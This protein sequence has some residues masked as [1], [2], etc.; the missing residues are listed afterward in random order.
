MDDPFDSDLLDAM[1]E[2][3][4]LAEAEGDLGDGADGEAFGDAAAEDLFADG[5]EASSDEADV[6]ADGS[7][8]AADAWDEGDAGEVDAMTLWNAF[9]EDVAAGLDEAD[10]DEFLGRLLGGLT[11]VGGM[12]G[13]G[14]R[15]A[16]GVAGRVAGT[17]Q[18][19]G[20]IAGRA[21]SMIG[22]TAPVMQGAAQM[23]RVLGAPG[24]GARLDSLGRGL[25]HA[26]QLA[27]NVGVTA[28]GIGRGA[29]GVEQ[30]LQGRFRAGAGQAAAGLRQAV[31]GGQSIL[32][33]L[34]RLFGSGGN[35]FDDFDAMAELYI[36]EGMDEALP[37]AV[38]LAARAAARGLGFGNIS[39]LSLAARRSL[40]RGV[41]AAA[42]E[43]IQRR[44][45][46]AVRA[47]PRLV[48][49][50]ARVARRNAPTPARAVRT[51]RQG[52]PQTARRVAANPQALRRLARPVPPGRAVGR[53]PALGH[54]TSGN[55]IGARRTFHID[56]PATLTITPR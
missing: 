40:V 42:R 2:A 56:G 37:A 15:T 32:A 26:G 19:V 10:E 22:A 49:S 5:Q 3:D 24:V 12:I 29:G 50:A 30:I 33:H 13:R 43:L 51:L 6:F 23:A 18:Q 4:A 39:Q 48:Q 36:D 7:A 17:A 52:M 28:Q 44:G 38:A 25:G 27:H 47:L 46:Q 20:H 11:R 16:R 8:D 54:G 1:D 41:A 34:G 9:E 14:I 35:E 55:R 31:G 45:P 53:D 21:G